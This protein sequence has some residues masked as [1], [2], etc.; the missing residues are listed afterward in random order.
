M[1]FKVRNDYEEEH[2]LHYLEQQYFLTKRI[3]D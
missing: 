1:K 3:T 2:L